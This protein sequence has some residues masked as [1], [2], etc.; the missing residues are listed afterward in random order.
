MRAFSRPFPC[1]SCWFSLNSQTVFCCHRFSLLPLSP[2]QLWSDHLT[3]VD[4]E[5]GLSHNICKKKTHK[6]ISQRM[7]AY[8]CN[9]LS[10]E[11]MHEHSFTWLAF[12][13]EVFRYPMDKRTHLKNP[14]KVNLSVFFF[15]S[16]NVFFKKPKT[17]A[18]QKL[19]FNSRISRF[20]S[21][22]KRVYYDR[23]HCRF[24]QV[25]LCI[26]F[27]VKQPVYFRLASNLSCVLEDVQ[28]NGRFVLYPVELV[29]LPYPRLKS[30]AQYKKNQY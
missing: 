3:Q 25:T 19:W 24:G 28:D 21:Q 27:P 22:L 16:I 1:V 9:I 6:Q 23:K 11:Y 10:T 4:W 8:T 30:S 5:D 14:S 29:D 26:H 2:L 13:K 18:V 15:H 20:L 7:I 17:E 12:K